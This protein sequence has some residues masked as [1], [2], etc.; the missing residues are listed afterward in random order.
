M[1]PKFLRTSRR[2]L[3]R[4]QIAALKIIG[5]GNLN[6]AFQQPARDFTGALNMAWMVSIVLILF[7]AVGKF[8]FHETSFIP[9]LPYVAAGVLVLDYL[10][11]RLAKK[12]RPNN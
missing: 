10:L 11:A 12:F 6:L 5:S 7:Y 1:K 8:A 2:L 3:K 9:Y 4:R